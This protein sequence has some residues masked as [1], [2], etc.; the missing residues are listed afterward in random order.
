MT[1][2]PDI[3]S[4]AMRAAGADDW[5]IQAA[6]AALLIAAGCAAAWRQKITAA[7]RNRKQP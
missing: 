6:A 2:L 7:W 4:T 3:V 5:R 1:N